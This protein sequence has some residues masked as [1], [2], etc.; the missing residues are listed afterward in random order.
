MIIVIDYGMGNLGSIANMIK[1]VGY[2]CII[3]SDLEEIKKATK[4]ILPGVGSFDYMDFD[5]TKSLEILKEK[6]DY[7]PYEKKHYE[8]VF[9]RFYQGY[10]LPNKFNVDKRKLHFST[11]ICSGQ[12]TREFVI[13]EMK[14]KPYDNIN[15]LNEDK[16]FVLKKLSFSEREFQNYMQREPKLHSEYASNLWIL[17]LYRKYFK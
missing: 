14:K 2:K 15:Q 17:S 16:D 8:S 4:L 13:E 7:V 10:I 12:L 5:K 9:T 6:V 1:K 11:L 3:T